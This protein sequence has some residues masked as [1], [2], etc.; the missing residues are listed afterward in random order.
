MGGEP[1][2]L[3]PWREPVEPHAKARGDLEGLGKEDLTQSRKGRKC[4]DVGVGT[5]RGFSP[6]VTGFSS[7]YP[8]RQ[9]TQQHRLRIGHSLID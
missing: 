9:S 1:V 8:A 2:L 3:Q 6:R 5:R 7:F 4:E